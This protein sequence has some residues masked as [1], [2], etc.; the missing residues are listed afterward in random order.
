MYREIYLDNSATTKPFNEVVDYI[1]D[2]NR[3]TYGNPSSL[4]KKGIE[5]EKLIKAARESIAE[6][7]GVESREVYFT[8]G[9]TESNNLA[10]RGFL[11]ANPRKGKHI[12]ATEIE[13]PAVLEV[14]KYLA[15]S[16]YKVDFLRVDS[17]GLVDLE[18]LKSKINAE[19]ALISIIYVN[20][21]IGSIQPVNEIVKIKNQVNKDAVLHVDAVQAYGKLKLTPVKSGIDML[22]ISSH[23]IHGP[24][25]VGALYVNRAVRIKPLLLGGGQES[26]VRSGTENVSGICGF[27]LA[28]GLI[29]KELDRS[30][31]KVRGLRDEFIRLLREN[32][33]DFKLIS[34]EEALP[35]ILSIAFPGVKAEV[36]LHH[37]AERNVFVSTGSAC[38][39][40]KNIHSHVLK[41]IGVAPCDIEG[42]IRFSFSSFN[43][44]QDVEETVTYIKEILP[45][46]QIKRGGR[47]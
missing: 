29:Y 42:S 17:R 6:T 35:Y 15:G 18:D 21:E 41:A 19:T 39:S 8:S 36:L 7:L 46:I 24:K 9:G 10:I 45:K 3:N 20:N 40:R 44:I 37:L 5:A 11:E 2:I 33:T 12:L 34:N 1:G 25:G 4:H 30:F 26:L 38:S 28:A 32:I 27:G 16:G 47:K 43:S 13:H 22:T 23:K 31:D 14:F